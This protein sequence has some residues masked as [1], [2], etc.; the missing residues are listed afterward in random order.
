MDV[1]FF[2]KVNDPYGHEI[3]DQVLQS[4]AQSCPR[5]C[6]SLTLLHVMVVKS[7]LCCCLLHH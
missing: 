4:V 1:D 2:K 5:L 6:V 3:G 7:L